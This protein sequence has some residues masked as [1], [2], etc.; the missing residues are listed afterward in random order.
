MNQSIQ[1]IAD[2]VSEN[3]AAKA[4]A[5]PDPA[6]VSAADH[7]EILTELLDVVDNLV[8]AGSPATP[9]GV[10]WYESPTLTIVGNQVQIS[11]GIANVSGTLKTVPAKNFTVTL[12]AAGYKQPYSAFSDYVSTPAVHEIDGSAIVAETASYAWPTVPENR[13]PVANFMVTNAGIT[14]APMG[15]VKEVSVDGSTWLLPNANG[16]LTL[17]YSPADTGFFGSASLFIKAAFDAIVTAVK[18]RLPIEAGSTTGTALTFLTD[19]VYGS[20]ATPE[21]GNITADVTGAKLGVTN[22]IIHNA[23]TAPTF[24]SKF[25]KL[26]GSGTYTLGVKNYIYCQYVSATRIL[27]SINQ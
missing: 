4:T 10:T 27:Y 3:I 6:R 5:S 16:R 2:K 8:S 15:V 26:S 9:A 12:P 20:E 24:D 1:N 13:L 19:R 21:T 25:Y 17:T 18:A 11:A 22:L 23:G 7:A 14:Q